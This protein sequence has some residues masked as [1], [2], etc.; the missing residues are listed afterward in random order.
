M[1]N[2]AGKTLAQ[3]AAAA[4]IDWN[5]PGAL[6]D[7]L[8]AECRWAGG[9]T[10]N[11]N[12]AAFRPVTLIPQGRIFTP[13]LSALMIAKG[14]YTVR[15]LR[16]FSTSLEGTCFI[17]TDGETLTGADY[18]PSA[19]RLL[20]GELYGSVLWAPVS[21][22]VLN[23]GGGV[24]FPQWGNTFNSDASARWKVSAGIILSI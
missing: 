10:S 9:A 18:P 7:M 1:E 23:F 6:Q 5:V 21:D 14:K 12:I 13:S 11:K 22:L 15:F 2:Q 17:R 8:Q 19:S 3:F 20:G 24:F 4:A 16:V